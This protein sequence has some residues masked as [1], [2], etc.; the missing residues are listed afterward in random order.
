MEKII[1]LI[2]KL[3]KKGKQNLAFIVAVLRK[4]TFFPILLSFI[5]IL[6]N[7]EVNERKKDQI[8]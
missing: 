2:E 7:V 5:I 4:E 8:V 6:Q 1:S 3:C